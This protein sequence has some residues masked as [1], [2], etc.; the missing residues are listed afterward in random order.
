MQYCRIFCQWQWKQQYEVQGSK[1]IIGMRQLFNANGP[2]LVKTAHFL[3]FPVQY[4]WINYEIVHFLWYICSRMFWLFW[5][6]SVINIEIGQNCV[7]K[8]I[9][10]KWFTVPSKPQA[11]KFL[12][13][14]RQSVSFNICPNWYSRPFQTPRLD[15]KIFIILKPQPNQLLQLI[16]TN[17]QKWMLTFS[18]LFK[19][20]SHYITY[21]RS[22]TSKHG[23]NFYLVHSQILSFSNTAIFLCISWAKLS[24]IQI[25]PPLKSSLNAFKSDLTL[26]ELH[27][28]P[29]E[30]N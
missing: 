15:V 1:L 29:L 20:D 3:S 13:F 9:L 24:K 2:C 27:A 18:K 22:H 23:C 10:S 8:P 11:V 30:H 26:H 19:S 17:H 6:E 7:V 5:M 25:P 16:K 28:E 21:T 14:M 12:G 4:I